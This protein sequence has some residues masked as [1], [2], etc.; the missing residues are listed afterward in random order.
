MGA[1]C[2]LSR[3]NLI[4][5]DKK[6]TLAYRKAEKLAAG[7]KNPDQWSFN[8]K[9]KFIWRQIGVL[10]LSKK[11]LFW[12]WRWCRIEGTVTEWSWVRVK[13]VS[14]QNLPLQGFGVSSVSGKKL[15]MVIDID[16]L[17]KSGL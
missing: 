17:V 15:N 7:L 9:K 12:V 11:S 4:F 6:W 16:G 14:Q 3:T 10:A 8:L 5:R 1:G 13:V 2:W